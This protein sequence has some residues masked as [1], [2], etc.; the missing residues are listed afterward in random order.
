MSLDLL[1]MGMG[2]LNMLSGMQ[3]N[4]QQRAQE[5]AQHAIR[6]SNY[7][8]DTMIGNLQN[9][10]KNIEISRVNQARWR[11]NREIARAANM[12]RVLQEREL[13]KSIGGKL[14]QISRGH[15]RALDTLTSKIA[16]SGMTPESGTARALRK[17]ISSASGQE[18]QNL[19][20]NDYMVRQNIIREQEKALGSRDLYGYNQG[21]T[22]FAGP[23][24]QLVQT[25]KTS[26]L[27]AATMF[28]SGV[29]SGI[30]MYTDYTAA[31]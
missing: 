7:N 26:P 9:M 19:R 6:L 3:A 31:T 27:G 21:S 16:G 25:A 17:M 14:M 11:Q 1:M 18:L 10:M 5:Q 23:A 30:D 20:Q 8:R 12:T 29:A 13:K 28:A 15:N 4:A 24:P 22:Y 2:G